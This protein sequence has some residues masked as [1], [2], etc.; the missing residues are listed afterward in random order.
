MTGGSLAAAKTG[1]AGAGA[2]IAAFFGTELAA[3]FALN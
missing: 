2:G 1:I 3:R